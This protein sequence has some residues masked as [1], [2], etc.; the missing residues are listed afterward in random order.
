MVEDLEHPYQ[1]KKSLLNLVKTFYNGQLKRKRVNCG[2]VG[3]NG[4]QESIS[5]LESNGNAWLIPKSSGLITRRHRLFLRRNG[6]TGLSIK[7]LLNAILESM[8]QS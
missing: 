3:V 6:L 8:I 7:L 4:M 5:S 1:K 2:V